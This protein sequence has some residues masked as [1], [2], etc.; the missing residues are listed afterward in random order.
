MDVIRHMGARRDATRTGM[1]AVRDVARR[2]LVTVY[3]IPHSPESAVV[4]H[5]A[6]R[7]AIQ[8]GD[9]D[10]ARREMREHLSRVETDAERGMAS[11]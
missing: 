5:R 11:A 2:A 1:Q 8:A 3:V 9:P 6:I 4:E 10:R 7:A